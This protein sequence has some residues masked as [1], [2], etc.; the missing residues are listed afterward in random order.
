MRDAL[1]DREAHPSQ[2][3]T[4]D[5]TIAG[6]ARDLRDGRTTATAL[7]SEAIERAK[8]LEP[9]L[10]AWVTLDREGALRAAS[11]ADEEL[12]VGAHN[13]RPLLGVPIGV[14]DI[15]DVA[16]IP[17][18][19]GSPIYQ[20]SIPTTDATC[21]ARLKQA[22]AIVL[23]KTVTTE[24]AFIDPAPTRNPWDLEATPG[25]SSSGSAAAVS[26]LTVPAALGSQTAGSTLRPAAYTGIVG[27]KPTYGLISR[28]GIFPL[29]WT[30]DTV[31]V[32]SR[33]VEDAGLMLQAMAGH[34]PRDPFS[35]QTTIPDYAAE[36]GRHRAT[37]PRIGV[38]RE[39][40]EERST[41][42]V[43]EHFA[44]VLDV[45]QRTGA[46]INEFSFA[47]G[48]ERAMTAHRAVM[49][50]EAA[51]IHR[52]NFSERPHEFGPRIGAFVREG[53]TIS[54]VD[55][56]EAQRYRGRFRGQVEALFAE[57]DVLLTPTTPAPAPRDLTTTGDPSFQMPWTF[58]GLP[59]ISIPTGLSRDGL[60]LGV[61]L[62]G[63]TLEE[64]RLLGVARWCEEVLGVD[65]VPP[66]AA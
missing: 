3:Q 36:L 51:A 43:L 60:P 16:G 53:L 9:S 24:F 4:Q 59:T 8:A 39:F 32:L 45:L 5:F 61:Q 54:G 65:L 7:V 26:S 25:G 20:G 12:H 66:I 64:G 18:E 41:P 49:A 57:C 27:F 42:E 14:K 30:L 31:G 13:D 58:A 2:H 22:G 38:V 21:I 28:V 52:S 1:T 62:V 46:L 47:E 44:S 35:L 40:F 56:V 37:P 10:R 48:F 11:K 23:G 55:Y 34:D 17:T 33:T 19:A 50:T 15:Y 6:L 63:Q 29:A